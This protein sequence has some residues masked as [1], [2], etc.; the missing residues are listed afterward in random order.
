MSCAEQF[1]TPVVSIGLSKNPKRG[2]WTSC[3]YGKKGSI[4]VVCSCGGDIGS[5]GGGGGG[6]GGS[7]SNIGGVGGGCSGGWPSKRYFPLLSSCQ[8]FEAGNIFC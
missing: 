3:V 7:G 2:F 4:V 6:N 1:R 8:I 5:G